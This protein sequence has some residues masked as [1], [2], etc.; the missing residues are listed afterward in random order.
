MLCSVASVFR[1]QLTVE[2]NTEPNTELPA[3][4]NRSRNRKPKKPKFWFGSAR[5]GS[6][7]FAVF[8][9]FLP[10]LMDKISVRA[11]QIALWRRFGRPVSSLPAERPNTHFPHDRQT[12]I[13]RYGGT[14]IKYKT[15]GSKKDMML[16]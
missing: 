10:R 4:Q 5:L 3:A 6:V 15:K 7:R 9:D 2:P 8:G 11:S 14:E 1:L 12:I 16:G 13:I